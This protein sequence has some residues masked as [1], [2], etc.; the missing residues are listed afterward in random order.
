M[1]KLGRL[2]RG[3]AMERAATLLKQ[4]GLDNKVKRR[5]NR[6]RA[7]SSSASRSPGRWPTSRRCSCG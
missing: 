6:L 5:A 1:L 7:A 4:F 2:S 3:D